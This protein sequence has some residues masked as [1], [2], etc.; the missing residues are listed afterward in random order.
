MPK[1]KPSQKPPFLWQEVI[2]HNF[3][4]LDTPSLEL[5]LALLA[6]PH[7]IDK[8]GLTL[9]DQIATLK[10][11]YS[12]FS[13]LKT[14][15]PEQIKTSPK[16]HC[17]RYPLTVAILCNHTS[18]ILLLS[19]FGFEIQ[20]AFPQHCLL[21]CIQFL[22]PNFVND[23]ILPSLHAR[24]KSQ[25]HQANKEGF[26][27]LTMALFKYQEST[28]RTA[29]ADD[30]TL[31]K[32]QTEKL[33]LSLI[34]LG[35]N[36]NASRSQKLLP[37]PFAITHQMQSLTN[38]L[39]E[40]LDVNAISYADEKNL[41]PLMCAILNNDIPLIK[42]LLTIPNSTQSNVHGQNALH[43][44]SKHEHSRADRL[45]IKKLLDKA[46]VSYDLT[47]HQGNTPIMQ[48]CIAN[49]TDLTVCFAKKTNNLYAVN[50]DNQHI[51]SLMLERMMAP[52]FFL[53]LSHLD[54]KMS[55]LKENIQA[56]ES[57]KK[58][59]QPSLDHT[60]ELQSI[61]TKLDEYQRL[62]QS[63]TQLLTHSFQLSTRSKKLAFSLERIS[64]NP[65]IKFSLLSL[66]FIFLASNHE[67]R[68]P[69][70]K[71]L[72]AILTIITK[73]RLQH[74][75]QDSP[76]QLSLYLG[77]PSLAFLKAGLFIPSSDPRPKNKSDHPD[78]AL[79][80][81][82]DRIATVQRL[83]P[84]KPL[85]CP[86]L[87]TGIM[88]EY[89]LYQWTEDHWA[90]LGDTYLEV[91]FNDP[92][93]WRMLNELYIHLQGA[94]FS[95]YFMLDNAESPS[96]H[97]VERPM[98]KSLGAILLVLISKKKDAFCRVEDDDKIQSF[99]VPSKFKILNAPEVTLLSELYRGKGSVE[100]WRSCLTEW[101]SAFMA[102]TCP[103]Q[104]VISTEQ[105][106]SQLLR[107]CV[108]AIIIHEYTTTML[109]P[110]TDQSIIVLVHSLLML[111][112]A[113]DVKIRQ[114]HLTLLTPFLKGD[115][116][117]KSL[118][119]TLHNQPI[120][121]QKTLGLAT[122]VFRE[123]Q[124]SQPDIS[125]KFFSHI[126][127]YTV[128]KND[129]LVGENLL[130]SWLSLNNQY[131]SSTVPEARS[132]F[133]F[134]FSYCENHYS[135]PQYHHTVV[136]IFKDIIGPQLTYERLYNPVAPQ[137]GCVDF[138]LQ[139]DISSSIQCPILQHAL[140]LYEDQ[141]IVDQTKQSQKEEGFVASIESIVSDLKSGKSCLVESTQKKP[142]AQ[143]LLESLQR[144]EQELA[145]TQK[146][147]SQARAKYDEDLARHISQTHPES[148]LSDLHARII[149]L[150]ESNQ[151]LNSDYAELN[152]KFSQKQ[153]GH[154]LQLR[155]N[156]SLQ[157]EI[158]QLKSQ[159]ADPEK[160]RTIDDLRAHCNR[161]KAKI[162]LLHSQHHDL[163]ARL[164]YLE[165]QL[166]DSLSR[167]KSLQTRL[168]SK[169]PSTRSCSVAT[170]STQSLFHSELKTL[171][172]PVI[173][174]IEALLIL[175]ISPLSSES[176]RILWK[177]TSAI[178]LLRAQ[179]D[180]LPSTDLCR[181][182]FTDFSE[183]IDLFVE[184]PQRIE[185]LIKNLSESLSHSSIDFTLTQSAHDRLTIAFTSTPVVID[186]KVSQQLS[187]KQ[188]PS[189]LC[190][191]WNHS[192]KLWTPV[193]LPLYGHH[194]FLFGTTLANLDQF[195]SSNLYSFYW[196]LH[197]LI[198]TQALGLPVDCARQ[199]LQK[200]LE[201]LSVPRSSSLF[202]KDILSIMKRFEGSPYWS[203]CL[204]CLRT[205]LDPATPPLIDMVF[206][207]EAAYHADSLHQDFDESTDYLSA[208]I[209]L[210]TAWQTQETNLQLLESAPWDSISTV[211]T[212]SHSP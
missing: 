169:K 209:F 49:Q 197:Q 65:S 163:A 118:S 210:K 121:V 132:I 205:R 52:P 85:E 154:D 50:T 204:R 103:D 4:S 177:G 166:Q 31:L 29:S 159:L 97:F 149:S 150:E 92:Y 181:R 94:K 101:L 56:L 48:A 189:S 111:H 123:L 55:T 82:I 212:P 5:T 196:S 86:P 78:A 72:D 179:F 184:T 164:S 138:L 129:I 183:D 1:K 128:D 176:S 42:R 148:E 188:T 158:L 162:E 36:P 32:D 108:H 206:P 112:A 40:K 153:K 34:K 80:D 10:D 116:V 45:L 137:L 144:K 90:E 191:S 17:N 7:A 22:K 172:R 174:E 6:T 178:C 140:S 173:P 12:Q 106:L 100:F 87:L 71:I 35:L 27:P 68:T 91:C 75:I 190:F 79:A 146:N 21:S 53:V 165:S 19:Y 11:D 43:I 136:T 208:L 142:S 127:S 28:K 113:D 198:K 151:T 152:K 186:I 200:H 63:H 9:W 44:L 203:Q 84:K 23:F 20:D 64:G 125:H 25:L 18:A 67:C 51:L 133:E 30:L 8:E 96:Q 54:Q 175:V 61:Q 134:I 2:S 195:P 46:R 109:Q 119:L 3:R 187:P 110:L 117:I 83:L 122:L 37:L 143:S 16:I 104:P 59:L 60:L 99:G 13:E 211:P 167:E 192:L 170:V 81:Q 39:L 160:D 102:S 114:Q 15:I 120:C 126:L 171:S 26:C 194:A 77:Q 41:T 199:L 93:P 73:Y 180:T 58:S 135:D 88:N 201:F 70:S 98:K 62:L 147:L 24:L 139:P 182:L 57:R 157:Q 38:T 115:S 105:S 207:V 124:K 66:C 168:D 202:S 69:L 130:L 89:W 156:H 74:L 155:E 185:A 47:D 76:F 145:E 161:Q 141:R 107:Q 131:I 193:L 95:P 14:F 33:C